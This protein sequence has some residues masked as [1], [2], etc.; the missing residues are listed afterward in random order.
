MRLRQTLRR[1]EQ[2]DAGDITVTFVE[3]RC[4][5][6]LFE[7]L[8]SVPSVP[9]AKKRAGIYYVEGNMI[10]IQV[11]NRKRFSTDGNLW[12]RSLG[13]TLNVR[14]FDLIDKE[15]RKNQTN[16]SISAYVL[17]CWRRT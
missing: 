16:D 9:V 2:G 10:P 11:I 6:K 15:L 7:F 13:D 1:V 14:E 8:R 3:D 4:P 17:C 5:R 12:L